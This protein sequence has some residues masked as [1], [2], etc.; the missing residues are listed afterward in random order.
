MDR[1]VAGSTAHP[2]KML[3]AFAR[4]AIAAYSRRATRARSHVRHRHDAGR[5]STPWSQRHRRRVRAALG[6]ACRGQ[7]RSSPRPSVRPAGARFAWAM[8]RQLMSSVP[9]ELD[10]ARRPGV[11][12]ATVRE[13]GARP[14]QCR[15]RRGR[16]TRSSLFGRREQSRARRPACVDRR[17]AAD[18]HGLLNHAQAGWRRGGDGS[19][20]APRRSADRLSRPPC[21]ARLRT[22]AWCRCNA[23]SHCSLDFTRTGWSRARPSSNSSRCVGLATRACRCGSSLTRMCSCCGS[24]EG[25]SYSRG[26]VPRPCH[27]SRPDGALRAVLRHLRRGRRPSATQRPPGPRGTAF[28]PELAA[29]GSGVGSGGGELDFAGASRCPSANEAN[30]KPVDGLPPEVLDV[31]AVAAEIALQQRHPRQAA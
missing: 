6:R 8:P 11:D 21:S 4:R 17:A 20:V 30:G 27:P 3:P 24:R 23:S 5:G 2:A 12:I 18:L 10:R 29:A 13:L 16:Q 7:P 1:Y 9:R 19:P 15:G 25:R 14:R 26:K 31:I 28:S 22:A